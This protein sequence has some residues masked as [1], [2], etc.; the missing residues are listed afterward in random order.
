MAAE[1]PKKQEGET[2]FVNYMDASKNYDSARDPLGC[3]IILGSMAMSGTG[4]PLHE[5]HLLDEG[6]GTGNYVSKLI[7]SVG[8]VTMQDFSEGMLDKARAKFKGHPKV[9]SIDQGDVCAMAYPDATYDA[10]INNQ[11]VQHIET[12]ETRPTRANLR[13]CCKEAYRVLKPGGSFII[14]TRSKEPRYD[15]LYW[16]SV[17]APKAVAAMSER[18]PS[19]DD[20]RVAMEEA[21][22][23]ITQCVTPKYASIMNKTHYYDPAGVFSEAWRR[24]ESWWSLVSPEELASLQAEMKKKIDEG[25]ADA[26]IK[27]RDELRVRSGQV[28]FICGKKPLSC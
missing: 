27:E 15:D 1:M 28:L 11:V 10:C 18:V 23:E 6:C 9:K 4:V 2:S 21:G 3:D 24:G 8:T 17:L 26:W 5:Q 19:R 12:D 22:F 13:A 25:T 7:G 20:C 16:Y 14:S